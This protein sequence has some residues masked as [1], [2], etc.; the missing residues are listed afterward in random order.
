MI[1]TPHYVNLGVRDYLRD[2]DRSTDRLWAA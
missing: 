2:D 1:R